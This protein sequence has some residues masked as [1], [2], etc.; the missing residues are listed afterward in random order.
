M[1]IQ[2]IALVLVATALGAQTIILMDGSGN[3]KAGIM[4]LIVLIPM[5]VVLAASIV[6]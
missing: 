1:I 6:S 2:V 5:L 4:W 3:R